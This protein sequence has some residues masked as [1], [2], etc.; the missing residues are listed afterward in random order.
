MSLQDHQISR[1]V[2]PKASGLLAERLRDL[3]LQGHFSSGNM[4]PP[5]REL[6]SESGLSRGTVR[7]ALKILETQNLV[8]IR[9]G[10][11]RVSVPKRFD[12]V[13]STK[14]F[15]R[16]NGVTLASL[17]DCRVA[18]E[19]MLA[20]LAAAHRTEVELANL[21]ELQTKFAASVNDT[22]R[23]RTLNFQWHLAIARASLNE[24][25]TALM[26]AISTPVL[27]ATGYESITT[28]ESR[29]AAVAAHAQIMDAI[30]SGNGEA[31]ASAMVAHLMAYNALV[32]PARI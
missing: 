20:R 6:V 21:E 29:R 11:A 13:R 10:G 3:I 32:K 2:V 17:L 16:A 18:I 24:P 28:P 4:L 31:A 19:P 23:Y 30:Q 14:L 5:E 9:S 12:L 27:E 7:E 1:V 26:E 8:V 22:Q 15:V 25:L